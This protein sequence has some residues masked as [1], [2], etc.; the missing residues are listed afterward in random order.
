MAQNTQQ[1]LIALTDS[2]ARAGVAV[3]RPVV[4]EHS[5]T[6][7]RALTTVRKNSQLVALHIPHYWAVYVHDGR[8]APVRARNGGVYLVW[9]RDRDADP[10]GIKQERYSEWRHLT[11]EEFQRGLLLNKAARK[12]GLDPPMIVVRQVTKP[13]PPTR[14][15]MNTHGMKPFRNRAGDVAETAFREHALNYLRKQLGLSNVASLR[16]ALGVSERGGS[17]PLGIDM[18][19]IRE[20]IIVRI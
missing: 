9:F 19:P 17:A 10:R 7:A 20:K 13:T 2:L 12:L 16:T 4:R 18:K 1:F 11:S 5:K 3:A 8:R 6:L 15:F 14:F